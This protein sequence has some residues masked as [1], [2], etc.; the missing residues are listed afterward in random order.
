MTNETQ[1]VEELREVCK[2]LIG[3]EAVVTAA[4]SVDGQGP[5]SMAGI[6]SKVTD[7]QEVSLNNDGHTAPGFMVVV[8]WGY[9]LTMTSGAKVETA[10]PSPNRPPDTLTPAECHARLGAAHIVIEA[11]LAAIQEVAASAISSKSAAG[12]L[13]ATLAA[14]EGETSPTRLGIHPASRWGIALAV[15]S[16]AQQ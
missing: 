9:A 11:Y 12:A 1:D 14:L 7:I 10:P 6:I 8:D 4:P 5:H 13:R 3:T 15:M 16:E 2:G